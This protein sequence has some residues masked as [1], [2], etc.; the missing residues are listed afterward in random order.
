MNEITLLFDYKAS[1][2][3]ILGLEEF[4]KSLKSEY[5]VNVRPNR[6]PQAG[7]IWDILVEFYIN[8][9]LS[10][11]II[12]AVAGGMLWDGV[13]IGARRFMIEPILQAFKRL[14]EQNEYLDYTPIFKMTFDDV[15]LKFYGIDK[16]FFTGVSDAFKILFKHYQEIINLSEQELFVI[17]IPAFLNEEIKD[18]EVYIVD[19]Y[20]ESE[21]K[22][23]TKF[24]ALSYTLDHERDVLDVANLNLLDKDWERE[25][26]KFKSR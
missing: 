24:W 3:K 9:S 4:Q 13:K 1:G 15:Q 23:F 5:M 21:R 10:D 8:V 20:I 26:R 25:G 18:R 22:D 14:E 19:P 11:F 16:G 7:G 12:G 6:G 17:H 2:G